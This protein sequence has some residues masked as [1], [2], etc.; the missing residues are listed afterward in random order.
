MLTVADFLDHLLRET[1]SKKLINLRRSYF[2]HQ[3]ADSM[4]LSGGIDAIKGVYQ[5][6]RAVEVRS[7]YHVTQNG[8]A[9]TTT[10]AANWL[11]MLT[12]RMQ[13]SGIRRTW[14]NSLT[15]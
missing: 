12:F 4:K 8:I 9:N 15:R 10:R 11:S 1:P 14:S 7:L 13:F 5:S 3:P 6:L 2:A